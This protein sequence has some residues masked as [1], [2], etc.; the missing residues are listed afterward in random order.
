MADRVALVTGGTRGLGFET[1]R[2]LAA[3]GFE[4][5]LTGRKASDGEAAVAKIQ[6]RH[7]QAKVRSLVLDLASLDAVRAFAADFHRLE[8]PLHLLVSNAG[9]MTTDPKLAFT[10][11]GFELP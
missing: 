6:A 3:S 7:P 5:V 8:L 1:A 11:E 9:L 4:V 2:K 10:K